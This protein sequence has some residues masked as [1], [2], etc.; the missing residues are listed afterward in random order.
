MVHE[1][2]PKQISRRDFLKVGYGIMLARLLE[3]KPGNEGVIDILPAKIVTHSAWPLDGEPGQ[4]MG[5]GIVPGMGYVHLQPTVRIDKDAPGY[6]QV[7]DGNYHVGIDFNLSNDD[8]DCGAPTRLILDGACVYAGE[9]DKRDLGT[10]AIFVHLLPNHELV[11]SRYT[12][13]LNFD[14]IPGKDYPA[15]EIVGSVGKS[16][17]EKGRCHLHLDIADRDIFEWHYTG[18]FEDPRWYPY[19]VPLW[20]LEMHYLDPAELI[21]TFPSWKERKKVE[22]SDEERNGL[23]PY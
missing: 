14:A 15:G 17:W 5:N 16:G 11:Y 1:E 2:E 12:H 7:P 18:I 13:L 3:E 23:R 9:D 20:F 19:K 22:I 21:P 6:V 8:T 10:T 4:L